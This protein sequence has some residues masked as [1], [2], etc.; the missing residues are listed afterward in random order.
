[1]YIYR[2]IY[3]ERERESMGFDIPYT[4]WVRYL[5][6]APWYLLLARWSTRSAYCGYIHLYIHGWQVVWWTWYRLNTTMTL[7]QQIFSRVA[8]VWFPIRSGVFSWKHCDFRLWED[9]LKFATSWPKGFVLVVLAAWFTL[10]DIYPWAIYVEM[11]LQPPGWH[12][13][14]FKGFGFQA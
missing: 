4:W 11:L 5:L 9:F 14:T 1:M 8:P 12:Y 3:I 7:F 6:L 13:I 2:Y 10:L